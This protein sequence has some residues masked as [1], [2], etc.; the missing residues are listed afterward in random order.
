LK[1]VY[2]FHG[3]I[4]SSEHVQIP[5]F[6]HHQQWLDLFARWWREGFQLF[7]ANAL[8][9]SFTFTA[10]L[11][12]PGWWYAMRGVDGYELS[13]RWAEALVLADLAREL[14]ASLDGEGG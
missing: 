7:R 3:R 8:A 11:G 9:E 1:R 5:L 2:A 4:A 6:P 12:P 14:W 13:D 10:E